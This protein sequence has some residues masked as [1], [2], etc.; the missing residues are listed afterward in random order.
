MRPPTQLTA[1]TVIAAL[2]IL[3]ACSGSD[4]TSGTSD[5]VRA[6]ASTETTLPDTTTPDVTTPDSASPD[7]SAPDRTDDASTS[8]PTVATTP[9]R[10]TTPTGSIVAGDGEFPGGTAAGDLVAGWLSPQGQLY[11]GEAAP[12]PEVQAAICDYLVGTPSEVGE[13]ALLTGDITLEEPAGYT[14]LGGNGAGFQCGYQS[15]GEFAFGLVIWNEDLNVQI[16]DQSGTVIVE[17]PNGLWGATS[18]DP[19]WTGSQ[20]DEAASQRWIA[21]AGSRVTSV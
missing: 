13:A 2:A 4:D 11:F 20:I 3:S 6:P 14:S 1:V 19:S 8:T 15:D 12:G 16:G 21:E 17:L 10:A 7:V 18:Y 9:G 5:P